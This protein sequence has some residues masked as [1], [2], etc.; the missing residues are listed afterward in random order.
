MGE[1]GRKSRF[2][3]PVK[4]SDYLT[5]GLHKKD[6]ILE[7]YTLFNTIHN[8]LPQSVPLNRIRIW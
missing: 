2:T 8:I 6:V 7:T 1:A 5:C 3:V 4:E